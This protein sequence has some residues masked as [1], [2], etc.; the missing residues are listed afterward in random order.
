MIKRLFQNKLYKNVLMLLTGTTIAQAIPIAI[1]PILTRIYTPEDF[2]LLALFISI[3]SIMGVIATARYELAIML[4]ED[5]DDAKNLVALSILISATI[6]SLLL[7]IFII[8]GEGLANLLGNSQIYSWLFLV[9]LSVLFT[10]IYQS[11]SY[12]SNRKQQ[13]RRLAINKVTQST[14]TAG[15][16]LIIGTVK[17]GAF[18]LI[19]GTILAQ[20]VATSRLVI[21]SFKNEK[22]SINQVSFIQMKTLASRYDQFPKI[23][24][25]SGLLNTASIQM[26][27][28]LL[29]VFFNSTI[30][31]W[32]S[33]AHRVLSM[34][35]SVLGSAVGQVFFQVSSDIKHEDPLKL[36]RMTYKA[37]KSMLFIG[38][39]PMSII[40]AFGD[41]LFGFI[42]GDEWRIA[43]EYARLLSIWLLLV[44]VSSPLSLLFTVLEKEGVALLFNIAIFLSRIIA[45]IIGAVILKDAFVAVLLFSIS[46]IVFWLWHC[47]YLLKM[48]GVSYIK[49]LAYTL[50]IIG[51]GLGVGIFV[52]YILLQNIW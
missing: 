50:R 32:Y 49:S 26:P 9:P 19:F 8:W 52:R 29:S 37:Y 21:Q 47:I 48:V 6:G 51:G 27:I 23:S 17:G 35:M 40:F 13:Y 25:W 34:P 36:R 4:P 43:G 45:L 38:L 5:D 22:L 16:N 30:V 46:G 3:T 18:G 44:F 42:F 24:M 12:W 11:F 39:L 7:I 10:G 14:T 31:G 1:S 28:F 41:I 15:T 2:G 33:L 20:F